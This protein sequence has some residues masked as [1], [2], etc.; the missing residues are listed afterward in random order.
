[1]SVNPDEILLTILSYD[2]ILSTITKDEETIK[3]FKKYFEL[4]LIFNKNIKK[5]FPDIDN[6]RLN[7]II[8]DLI[9]IYN[10]IK[11][12][13]PTLIKSSNKE[14]FDEKIENISIFIKNTLNNRYDNKNIKLFIENFLSLFYKITF[15]P[16]NELIIEE[17]SQNFNK[18][19]FLKIINEELTSFIKY[20]EENRN[21]FLTYQNIQKYKRSLIEQYSKER[22]DN[23]VLKIKKLDFL[24]KLSNK[25]EIT[26]DDLLIIILELMNFMEYFR[27]FRTD[28]KDIN[29]LIIF[30]KE[31]YQIFTQEE[32]KNI[33]TKL[34]DIY[35]ELKLKGGS[36]N[37]KLIKDIKE[38]LNKYKNRNNH[39]LKQILKILKQS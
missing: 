18:E 28:L 36:I 23:F 29:Y 27:G 26:I 16:Q 39:K 33:I 11:L 12:M 4:E 10:L 19:I 21:D 2:D 35:K 24:I 34:L 31:K 7:Q 14:E 22:I 15:K 5:L 13:Y 17:V 6:I 1:M 38:F 9:E 37:H 8:K 32:I 30:F 25:L 20:Y 3:S